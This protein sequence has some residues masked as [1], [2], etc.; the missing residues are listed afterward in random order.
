MSVSDY[1]L[2]W[3]SLVSRGKDPLFFSGDGAEFLLSQNG[4]AFLNFWIQ[5]LPQK[6]TFSRWFL[7]RAKEARDKAPSYGPI[8]AVLCCDD[9]WLPEDV[10]RMAERGGFKF[11]WLVC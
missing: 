8:S 6:E 3:R 11:L 10:H 5:T 2:S 4:N 9:N 1:V 7:D